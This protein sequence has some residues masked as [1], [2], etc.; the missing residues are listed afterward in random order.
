V[1]DGETAVLVFGA[2]LTGADRVGE[3]VWPSGG[4]PSLLLGAPMTLDQFNMERSLFLG[5]MV[6]L[7]LL[8]PQSG[9]RFCVSQ[10]IEL[11]GPVHIAAPVTV[12]SLIGQ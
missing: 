3:T 4:G 11:L 6:T 7:G 5:A 12:D 9:N 10:A 2:C 1:W 8:G